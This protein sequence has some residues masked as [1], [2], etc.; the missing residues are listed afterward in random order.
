MLKKVIKDLLPPALKRFLSGLFYGWHGNFPTWAEATKKCGGYNSPEILKKVKKSSLM[1]KN[2]SAAF[3]RD[4]VLFENIEYSFPLLSGLLWIANQNN[5]KLNVLDFGGS[6]GSTYFQNK[7]FLDSQNEVNWCIVEQPGFV[8]TGKE[9]FE[10]EK[11]HFFYSIEDCMNE[12]D[13][14]AVI[15]SSVL[16]YM[17]EPY[18]LL[19]N[20]RL[21]GI[22][23]LIIDRTPFIEGN[24]RITI[25]KVK[26]SIYSG[27]YPCW[28]FN[29]NKFLTTLKKEYKLLLEFD[30]LDEANISSKFK[31]F[32]F[33]KI[34][35]EKY[36][37]I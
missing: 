19:E 11:L 8:K 13:I 31:G 35:S 21:R 20:I 25:Q 17:E 33:Q 14:D 22:R 32:L 6:L 27:S 7:F 12:Y 28:F 36:K 5:G 2:G 34:E 26:P 29:E 23:Y 16:Q 18:V 37:V 30:A 4:S 9:S 1:V 3:E 10:D 15:L 24:D